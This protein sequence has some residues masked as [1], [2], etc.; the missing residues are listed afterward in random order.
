MDDSL[1]KI[2]DDVL[3]VAF[4][5]YAYGVHLAG[6]G[7]YCWYLARE[8]RKLGVHVDVFTTDFHF[9]T[10]GLPY[11]YIKN[12]FLNLRKYDVVHSDV[13]AGFFLYHPCMVE[14]YH[15]DYK[16][17]SDVNSLL[18][19][20]LETLQCR[21]VKHIIVPSLMTK[22]GLVNHGVKE[23][24]ITVIHHGVDHELFRRNEALRHLMR[25]EYELTKSFVAISVGRLVR[26]KRHTDIIEALSKIPE[27]TIILVGEGEE[28]D[29]IVSLARERGVRLLHF[30]NISDKFL[31]S[32][33]SAADVY[34]HASVVEGFGLTVVEAMACGLPI[35]CY[36]VA[37]F[38]NIISDAGL[39]LKPKDVDGIFQAVQSLREND[40]ER[41]ALGRNAL[42][43][44][45]A[46]TWKKTAEGHLR[47]YRK[48]LS[49]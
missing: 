8:L 25:E 47:V 28:K 5:P 9:K 46:F 45:K 32:L 10:W 3:K 29:R 43:K 18:F 42:R 41:V 39:L 17:P 24:K 40:A 20:G 1:R 27:T 19:H 31:A 2:G 48:L 36:D 6:L 13:G 26:H 23:D 35:V 11:F 22:N 30:Q 4:L 7:K 16:Q 37:D 38:R 44:S 33:Y 12:A 21:K 14:T 34:V 15:H 49:H